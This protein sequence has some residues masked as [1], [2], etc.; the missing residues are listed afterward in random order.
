[1]KTVTCIALAALLA[2]PVA[3]RAAPRDYD[4][5]EVIRL[6]HQWLHAS[7]TRDKAVLTR[8]LA[9]DFIDT[10]YRGTLRTKA[11]VLAASAAPGT[12]Q[13]LA[14][15]KVRFYGDTAIMTGVNHVVGPNKAWTADVRF[16]DVYVKRGG[17]WQAV[18]AQETPVSPQR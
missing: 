9:D 5:G 10:S 18:S 4:R 15:L 7:M 3:A 14:S 11:D 8:I 6:A 16:T 1:M 17:R 2:I 13:H 12:S